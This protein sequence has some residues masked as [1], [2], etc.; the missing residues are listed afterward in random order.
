MLRGHRRNS[1]HQLLCTQEEEIEIEPGCPRMRGHW[2]QST[3]RVSLVERV[4]LVVAADPVD[5][6]R[7]DDFC[8]RLLFIR[9]FHSWF[10][11]EVIEAGECS[12][13]AGGVGRGSWLL[14]SAPEVFRIVLDVPSLFPVDLPG[15]SPVE[16]ERRVGSACRLRTPG[17]SMKFDSFDRLRLFFHDVSRSAKKGRRFPCP[18]PDGSGDGDFDLDRD[19]IISKLFEKLFDRLEWLLAVNGD[20]QFQFLAGNATPAKLEDTSKSSS[21]LT[22][23]S[24]LFLPDM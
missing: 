23:F 9:F 3:W 13:V 18:V 22:T 15:Q 4:V 2:D 12:G 21:E 6:S 19:I 16:S 10:F 7:V 17:P 24:S 20:F 11:E 14:L 5:T 8:C 1:Y